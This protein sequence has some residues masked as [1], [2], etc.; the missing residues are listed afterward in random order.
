M[1]KRM[2]RVGVAASDTC[3][4][5][6]SP[7]AFDAATT[8]CSDVCEDLTDNAMS[9]ATLRLSSSMTT[10]NT[11]GRGTQT[12]RCQATAQKKIDDVVSAINAAANDVT[13]QGSAAV[14]DH[15]T[16]LGSAGDVPWNRYRFHE[17]TLYVNQGLIGQRTCTSPTNVVM[18]VHLFAQSIKEASTNDWT[19][20][21]PDF[22]IRGA[23]G[24]PL[25]R[26]WFDGGSAQ[27]SL[28]DWPKHICSDGGE[29]SVRVPLMATDLSTLQARS[30]GVSWISTTEPFFFDFACPYGSQDEANG[31]PCPNRDI[32][33]FQQLQDELSQP[34]GPEFQNC[35]ES[36]VADYE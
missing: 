27:G 7:S 24:R 11:C 6:C 30:T 15:R 2:A 18:R 12:H 33:A 19:L 8:Q 36:D 29:G 4:Q 20:M 26:G 32:T 13:W 23:A 14:D 10:L 31:G 3:K 25:W 16:I 1:G 35:F 22:E 9:T 21:F 28:S 17:R 5:D 34:S